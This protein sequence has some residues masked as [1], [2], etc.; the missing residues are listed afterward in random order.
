VTEFF[1]DYAL[2]PGQGFWKDRKEASYQLLI[3]SEKL[4]AVK[5]LASKLK[6]SFR[7][8]SIMEIRHRNSAVVFH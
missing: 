4:K 6:K 7:Q 5:S 8:D 3:A 2:F 1:D